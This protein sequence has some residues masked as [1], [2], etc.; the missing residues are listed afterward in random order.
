M[1]A[2]NPD[3]PGRVRRVLLPVGALIGVVAAAG[4]TV[5]ALRATSGPECK[6]TLPLKIAVTPAIEEVV[7][8]AADDYQTTQ[9]MVDG[10]CVQVQ[11]EARGAAD[12]AN[13]LPTA[14]INP[15]ALWVPDSSMWAAETQRQAGD[16][17]EEAP[18]LDILD[19]LASS[20]LVIAGSEASMSALGWPITPV[21]WAKVV[22]PKEP[23][24]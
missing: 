1:T 4:I 23:V 18:R 24:T 14:Q 7:R 3:G 12:V 11:V 9:P 15:P 21:T 13:E 5:V 10:K 17:G 16:E 19:P 22:D 2:R 20:P 8:G 6:G